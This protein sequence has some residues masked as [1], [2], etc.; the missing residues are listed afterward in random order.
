[1]CE[2][3]IPWILAA[4]VLPMTLKTWFSLSF[5]W[6]VKGAIQGGVS[7][8]T[9]HWVDSYCVNHGKEK[10]YD[11]CK[12]DKNMSGKVLGPIDWIDIKTQIGGVPFSLNLR[13]SNVTDSDLIEH[14]VDQ[15][16]LRRLDL[17]YCHD[18]TYKGVR[19]FRKLRPD[20]RVKHNSFRYWNYFIG[21]LIFTCTLIKLIS[22]YC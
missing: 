3:L 5:L 22:V 7:K 12:E 11:I 14:L 18:I 2:N 1:M 8:I 6:A 13:G 9:E 17:C 4:E 19:K 16:L 10:K 15:K 21:F 20:C